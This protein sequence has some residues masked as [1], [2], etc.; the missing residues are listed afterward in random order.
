MG[1]AIDVLRDRWTLLILRNATIG[2][3]RFE[4]FRAELGIADNI[5][6]NQL[7]RVIHQACGSDLAH[8]CHCAACER[9][10]ERTESRG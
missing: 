10:V 4:D 7:A 9:A 3:T 2:V 5:L 1:R 8:D 6:S